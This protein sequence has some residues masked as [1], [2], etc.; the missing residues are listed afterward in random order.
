MCA[1]TGQIQALSN[2]CIYLS[3]TKGA[4]LQRQTDVDNGNDFGIA[5]INNASKKSKIVM[6]AEEWL[7]AGT[8][9]TGQQMSWF[10]DRMVGVIPDASSTQQ[11]PHCTR[12]SIISG[13]AVVSTLKIG[14]RNRDDGRRDRK[15]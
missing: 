4:V 12:P 15:N 5:F 3:G 6:N 14:D 8:D 7:F 13:S 9:F 2:N 11:T 10:T 1:G